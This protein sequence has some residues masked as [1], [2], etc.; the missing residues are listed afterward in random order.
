MQ[1]ELVPG[2]AIL[3]VLFL[4]TLWAFKI[5]QARGRLPPGP[6]PW[7]FLG[8]LLQKDVLPLHKTYPKVRQSLIVSFLSG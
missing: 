1:V 4:L 3:L 8:N 7:L 5:H 2:A 6:K